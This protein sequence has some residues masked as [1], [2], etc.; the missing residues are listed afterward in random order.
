MKP[1]IVKRKLAAGKPVLSGKVNFENPAIIE[2]MGM[3]GFDCVWVCNEHQYPDDS[4]LE[5]L[6]C[7]ARV[8]GM[9]FLL[10]RNMAGYEDVLHPLEMG[11]HGLMIPRVT[12]PAYLEK[13]VRMVKFPPEGS[14]GLDGVNADADFGLLPLTDYLTRANRETFIIAQIE[15][16]LALERLDE[17]AAV[18][19]VDVLLVGP[20]D[21]SVQF[22]IPGQL[23]DKRIL[24][25]FDK[26]AKA[27]QKHG[28]R[29]GTT[30]AD[31]EDARKLI[32]RGY[33]FFG[34]SVDYYPVRNHMT[35][36]KETFGPV[37]FTFGE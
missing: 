30:T 4:K 22:G 16:P 10:R 17:I 23:R 34:T 37:G 35:K 33:L 31:P 25:A 32:E 26:V 2:M 7:A 27:C 5:H 15:E 12:D 18:K 19:H 21:L 3:L 13:V 36:L 20:G 28:K 1:S 24:D 29:A 11:V 8:A 14:R 6:V 9:D